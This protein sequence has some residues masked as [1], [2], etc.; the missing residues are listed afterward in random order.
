MANYAWC[1]IDAEFADKQSAEA[2]EALIHLNDNMPEGHG[3]D[4]G[5]GD[6]WL[7][8]QQVTV[9][10]NR[11]VFTGDVKWGLDDNQARG[12]IRWFIE[13]GV[14][15]EIIVDIEEGGNNIYGIY[16]YKK[17]KLVYKSVDTASK[18]WDKYHNAANAEGIEPIENILGNPKHKDYRERDVPLEGK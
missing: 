14:T 10:D 11:L 17:G 2:A 1:C 12:L 3:K 7:F 13:R 9:Q 8:D 4:L 5:M 6:N 16:E 18:E 15:G